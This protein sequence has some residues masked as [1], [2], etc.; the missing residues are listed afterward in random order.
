MELKHAR[1]ELIDQRLWSI[2]REEGR[3][4]LS[5]QLLGGQI[6]ELQGLLQT[7]LDNLGGERAGPP[8]VRGYQHQRTGDLRVAPIEL[9][10][11]SAA[12]GQPDDVRSFEP[13]PL[14]ERGETV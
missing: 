8:R 13:D 3:D 6:G 14:D 4:H 5:Y 9:D 12:E 7:E 2:R 1:R 11:Q 10:S